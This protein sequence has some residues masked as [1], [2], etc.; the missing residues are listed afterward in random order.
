MAE[1]ERL[2]PIRSWHDHEDVINTT[3]TISRCEVVKSDVLSV[4]NDWCFGKDEVVKDWDSDPRK[5]EAEREGG[6]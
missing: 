3:L 5:A 2:I 6:D 4:L 1:Y